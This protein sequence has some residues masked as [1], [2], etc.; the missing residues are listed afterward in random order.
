MAPLPEPQIRALIADCLRPGH[1]FVG[2]A[3]TLTWEH[4]PREEIVWEVFRGRLLDPAHT[5]QH[6]IFESWNIYQEDAEGRSSQP[7]LSVKLDTASGFIHVT[8]AIHCHAWE[9]YH[10]GDNVYLSRETRKWV[11][12]LVGSIAIERFPALAEL[13]AELTCRVFQAVIGSSRLPLTSVEAPLPAFSLGQ[14]AYCPRVEDDD[15]QPLR[16]Y[17]DLLAHGWP[18]SRLEQVKLL[19]TVLR[20]TPAAEIAAA[21]EVFAGLGLPACELPELLRRLFDEVALSPWTDFVPN[22][23]AFLQ[24]LTDQGQ[25]PLADHVDFLSY[26]LRQVVRHLTA[27]DLHVFHHQGA[28]Y[29]D[30]L[31]L[32]AVLKAYLAWIER[33]PEL[34]LPRAGDD[35]KAQTAKRVRR[36]A[37][38]QAWLLRR[39][40]EGL[41]VPDAPTSPGENARILPPPH[42]RVPDEQIMNAHKRQKRLYDGDPLDNHLKEHGHEVLDLSVRDLEQPIELRELGM[43][44]FVDRP[45]GVFK[46]PGEPDQTPLLS[47]EAFSRS[48]A[49]RRLDYLARELQLLSAARLEECHAR[50]APLEVTGQ[51]LPARPGTSRPGT[52]S[53]DDARRVADDFLFLRST[54][55]SIA[56]FLSVFD[57]TSLLPAEQWR[58][59]LRGERDGLLA[60]F[61]SQLRR[62]LEL[63]IDP[64]QGYES[65]GGLEYPRGL[66]VRDI[67]S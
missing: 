11:S 7:I 6:A 64:T 65:R 50:L 18:L 63:E 66:R 3:L 33:R 45:L 19:E 12:E 48:I 13:R 46:A 9:G 62:R 29:P 57:Q 10:A 4:V 52:V 22:T 2:P 15:P 49:A 55:R 42:L 30:A 60:V 23:L 32:D 20:S 59:I 31:L 61:D 26:L 27:Y 40:Y 24:A 67:P 34:F 21:A 37:L 14:L 17:R 28:N 44:V 38:R 41:A 47:Y 16:S 35:V 8:R 54:R 56:E 53:V 58:L 5:R 25:L 43:A 51:P 39:F 36:R 1:F